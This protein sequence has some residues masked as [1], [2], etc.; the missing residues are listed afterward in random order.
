M[1]AREEYAMFKTRVCEMLG[2]EHP[3]IQAG[4]G[5]VAMG[6]LAA[7]VSE[8]GGLGVIGAAMLTADQTREQI[9]K[10]KSLPCQPCC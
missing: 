7:A 8:A 2:I 5:G 10:V 3:I 1:N 4:M 6:D 9:Q